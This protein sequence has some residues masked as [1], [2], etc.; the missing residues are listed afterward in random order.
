[1]AV[2][3]YLGLLLILA[4]FT[5]L[6]KGDIWETAGD[7]TWLSKRIQIAERVPP[8][9]ITAQRIQR[10]FI[11]D[12]P[13]DPST[14]RILRRA[15]EFP[16]ASRTKRDV[17]A[18]FY[19]VIFAVDSSGSI[20]ETGFRAGIRAL[21]ILISRAKP[22]TIY[23][24]VSYSE[25]A[26]IEFSFKS[27]KE[28]VSL[29]HSARFLGFRT[30]TQDALRECRNLFTNKT[31]GVRMRSHKRVLIVTDGRSNVDKEL[32]LYQAFQL[33]LM[34][35]EVFVVA[36]GKY[37]KGIEEILGMASSFEKHLFRV[38]SLAGFARVVRMIPPWPYR[39]RGN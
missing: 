11:I 16:G 35:V 9:M 3:R 36:V 10:F 29:L 5:G 24:A 25:H 2:V 33:K 12:E 34:G 37:I 15:P 1:M 19:D 18:S 38:E 31:S 20:K 4:F 27:P 23:S 26:H 30:N 13:D 6:G 32:T 39:S 28:A 7:D 17:K 21:R 8:H 14:H 22:T